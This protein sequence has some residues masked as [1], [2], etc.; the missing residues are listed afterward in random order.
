MRQASTARALEREGSDMERYAQKARAL[1]MKA[2]GQI[3]GRRGSNLGSSRSLPT[4]PS[5]HGSL[6]AIAPGPI[7][8]Q[9]QDQ[10]LPRIR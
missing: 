9:P 5:K 3:G 7:A 8:A 1:N 10:A 4:L 2:S 6:K